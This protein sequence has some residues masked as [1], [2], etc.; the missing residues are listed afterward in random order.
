[1]FENIKGDLLAFT[2]ARNPNL[3]KNSVREDLKS[4]LQFSYF[5]VLTY[6]FFHWARGVRIPVVRQL[7]KIA[8]AICHK[9]A[10][11]CT[12]VYIDPAAEIG[13]GL[14]IHSMY[15]VLLGATKYGKNCTAASGVLVGSATRSIGDNVWLGPG[16]KIISDVTIGNN[17]VI[18]ANS[19]ILTD[20]PDNTTIVGVPAR[21]RLRGGR[22][23]RFK[24]LLR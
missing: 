18:V 11:I 13:P 12:G 19:L 24:K 15:G 17:V 22:P 14:V 2:A 10:A 23:Q 8:A 4:L 5:P 6:R 20:V 9:I 7:L 1:M 3:E 21:I 16:A